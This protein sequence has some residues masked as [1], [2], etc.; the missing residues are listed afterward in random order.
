M[1]STF[2]YKPLQDLA[3]II[4]LQGLQQTYYLPVPGELK[5]ECKHEPA[6]LTQT[7]KGYKCVCGVE[8]KR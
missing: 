1:K 3:E 2:N 5:A 8:F 7:E 6:L 4:K